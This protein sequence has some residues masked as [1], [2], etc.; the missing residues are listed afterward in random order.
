MTKEGPKRD[1]HQSNRAPSSPKGVPKSINMSF[2]TPLR[3]RERTK[4]KQD[5][6]PNSNSHPFWTLLAAP[7]RS[8]GGFWSPRG[9]LN[10]PKIDMMRIDRHIGGAKWA[11]KASR[12]GFRNVTEN[13]TKKVSQNLRFW[14]AKT[15][16][17]YY[18]V[19]QNQ[20]FGG[21]EKTSKND[22]K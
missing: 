8:K 17:K 15:S 3:H 2:G 12:R 22:R 6:I 5:L 10:S 1:E 13:V 19:I 7:G 18:K 16:T 4:R 20:G 11:K 21:S 14:D 9:F